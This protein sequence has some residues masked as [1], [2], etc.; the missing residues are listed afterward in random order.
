MV[1]GPR[2]PTS[3]TAPRAYLL[4]QPAAAIARHA[5]LLD[6]VP[7]RNDAR[8]VVTKAPEGRWF[9]DVAVRDRP[10]SLASVTG[11]LAATGISVEDAVVAVWDDGAAIES[12]RV[13]VQEPPDAA[14]L[15]AAIQAALASGRLETAPAP[16]VTATF[17][18]NA[19]PW[20]TVCEIRSP[21][22]AGLLHA[23]AAAFFAAGVRVAAA[24]VTIDGDDVVDRFEVTDEKGAKLAPNAEAAVRD[25]LASGVS[26]KRRRLGRTL[27]VR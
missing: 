1:T 3:T 4:R 16:E 8:V 10:G 23:I 12:F 14:S 17:D 2:P 27:S 5:T 25:Q 13:R 9:V 7:G 19:S 6:P 20:H 24:N 21:D 11:A 18:G 15:A 22:R 26:A